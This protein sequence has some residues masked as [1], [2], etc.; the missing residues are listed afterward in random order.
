M[1]PNFEKQLRA[2]KDHAKNEYAAR[3][4]GGQVRWFRPAEWNGN[5][6]DYAG[7][8]AP[9]AR[10]HAN[11][12]ILAAIKDPTSPGTTGDVV[13]AVTMIDALSAM[14]QSFKARHTLRRA[15]AMAHH[16]G[17]KLGHG[18]DN[19]PLVQLGMEYVRTVLAQAKTPRE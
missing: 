16:L 1:D 4:V 2:L 19:G 14:E 9:F 3:S 8:H 5:P 6:F 13:A 15:R 12:G 11:Q 17:R 18:D 10:D 7:L